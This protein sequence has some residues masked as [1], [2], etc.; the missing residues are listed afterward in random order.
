MGRAD[1]VDI[2]LMM[3]V[4]VF[5]RPCVNFASVGER[6]SKGGVNVVEMKLELFDGASTQRA[7]LRYATRSPCTGHRLI[8]LLGQFIRTY[9]T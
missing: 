1:W 3:V 6:V 5:S 8:F 7:A 2:F 9:Y 4:V